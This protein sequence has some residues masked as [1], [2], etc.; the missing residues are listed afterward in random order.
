MLAFI[1]ANIYSIVTFVIA[2]GLNLIFLEPI[3][4]LFIGL[5][6][7]INY[8][9]IS[10]KIGYFLIVILITVLYAFMIKGFYIHNKRTTFLISLILVSYGTYR[11]IFTD[12]ISFIGLNKLIVFADLILLIALFHFINLFVVR[13]KT[14]KIFK[15][16]ASDNNNFFIEDKV[17][18]NGVI[19]N[20]AI[21][22]KLLKVVKDFKPEE[23]FSIGLNA[24]WGYGKSSFL[25]RFHNIFKEQSPKEIIFWYRIWKNKGSNAII[26]NFFQELRSQLKPYSSEITDDINN[27]VDSILSLSNSEF[28]KFISVGKELLSENETLENYYN[29]INE[30][31]RKID[32]Q[33]IVLLDDLDRLESSEIM[34]SLKLIRTFSDFNNII[35]IA[36]YDREYIVRTM[37]SSKD[38]YLDKIFNVEINLL[39]FDSDLIIAELFRQVDLTFGIEITKKDNGNFNEAFK[40]LFVDLE[41]SPEEIQQAFLGNNSEVMP[42]TIN[43]KLSYKDFLPTYRDIKRFINEFKFNYSF[44]ESETDV[45]AQEYILFKLLIYKYREL[46]NLIFSNLN[47]LLKRTRLDSVNENNV[48]V[49]GNDNLNNIYEYDSSSQDNL[50]KRLSERN[51]SDNDF[52]II[53]A[54]M[55]RLFGKKSIH[56]YQNNQNTISK[57]Y[58]I[59]IYLRNNIVGGKVSVSQLLEAFE[60]N[61]LLGMVKGI[62]KS[63]EKIDI[64][65][66]NEIKQFIYNNPPNTLDQYLDQLRTIH[67]ILPN[68]NSYDDQKIIDLVRVA[69]HSFYGKNKPP[70]LKDIQKIINDSSLGF[71]D[72]MLRDI[73]LDYKRRNS[74][75]SYSSGML[76]RFS[77][78]EFNE[79]D[80]DK[81]Y[82]DKL[83]YLIEK[84][85][86]PE[87]VFSFYLQNV[88]AIVNE[89][90]VIKSLK[91]SSL[92]KNDL[93]NRFAAYFN[94]PMFESIRERISDTEGTFD[95]YSPNFNLAQ[96]FMSE[97]DYNSL[98]EDPFN[99]EKYEQFYN[100]G[101]DKLFEYLNN[102]VDLSSNSGINIDEKVFNRSKAFVKAYIS[103]NYKP[104]SK[105]QYDEVWNKPDLPF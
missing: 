25:Y 46:N 42:C 17:Y 41:L 54:V 47:E 9:S 6:S 28:H 10:F 87:L 79:E 69:F 19:D 82:I 93:Q 11:F 31:I 4:L 12:F 56:Y 20:E 76:K 22:Q 84:K 58:Y 83:I 1:R 33:I 32:K 51:Y 3:G 61:N 34:N 50:K 36:G 30:N 15:R 60:N 95:G 103:N 55:C 72:F 7:K 5:G 29:S 102:E 44:L 104:L 73:N 99:N 74:G 88:S 43:Y 49:F 2:I 101:W 80:L 71:L 77:N 98:L 70:F 89:K 105:E 38:N 75:L 96:I 63:I 27:Y 62:S 14:E 65:V 68:S 92:I 86:K 40:N 97:E 59:D 90:K 81:L 13:L 8:D 21:L 94:S 39:P 37:D 66:T 48:I 35:F 78:N 57:I 100:N 24:V 45:Y 23:A 52:D 18:K 85:S 67:F 91:A 16:P 53:N 26:E 64:H